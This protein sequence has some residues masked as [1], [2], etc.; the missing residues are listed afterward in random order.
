MSETEHETVA[1][2]HWTCFMIVLLLCCTQHDEIEL[3]TAELDARQ[4]ELDAKLI[5]LNKQVT[6]PL[7]FYG[8]F[9][10]YCNSWCANVPLW[11][12]ILY[13]CCC[14]CHHH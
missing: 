14:C 13:C 8:R 6:V 7:T 2:H 9:V 1:A 3:K 5:K 12:S 11:L 4:R 10:N